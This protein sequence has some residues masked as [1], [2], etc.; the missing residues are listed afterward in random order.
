MVESSLLSFLHSCFALLDSNPITSVLQPSLPPSLP[1]CFPSLLQFKQGLT[2]EECHRLAYE[3]AKDIIACGFDVK[4]TF[5]FSDLDY[6]G[7]LYPTVL[8]IQKLVTFNQARGIFGFTE[9]DSC[10]KIAFPAV[11]AAPSF[12]SSF[13]VVLG[14]GRKG[15]KEGGKE[16]MACL[17]PCAIDQDA[18]FRM[19][20]DVAPR[21]GYKKPSL[22]HS[23]FF[24][25][26]EVRRG[27]ERE[28]V[29]VGWPG[30]NETQTMGF[31]PLSLSLTSHV[32]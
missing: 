24:P 28:G 21:L 4:K 7:H 15:G 3:N 13:P 1:P 26:L 31:S 10:G 32:A 6:I 17:I 30:E 8:K 16:D 25:G 23:K 12:V 2:L 11:Q 27:R 19:T 29:R 9:S 5:I 14:R 20:R 18:Y 22:I